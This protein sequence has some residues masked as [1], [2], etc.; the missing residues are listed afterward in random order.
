MVD[1]I[2]KIYG[3]RVGFDLKSRHKRRQMVNNFMGDK[4][5]F[6]DADRI[7]EGSREKDGKGKESSERLEET[8]ILTKKINQ[9]QSKQSY[10]DVATRTHQQQRSGVISRSLPRQAER[11]HTDE[12]PVQPPPVDN[13]IKVRGLNAF[14]SEK[15]IGNIGV[16]APVQ[17]S[18]KSTIAK[19]MFMPSSTPHNNKKTESSGSSELIWHPSESTVSSAMKINRVRPKSSIMTKDR[20]EHTMKNIKKHIR[21]ER[22][23]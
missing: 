6:D 14:C 21:R 12:L 22:D 19:P 9:R 13:R 10:A 2:N 4:I 18:S 23:S 7:D 20:H 3:G 16:V 17:T 8:I 1:R 5:E 15:R 11:Q